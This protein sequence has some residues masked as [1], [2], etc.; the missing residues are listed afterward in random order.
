MAL[1][2]VAL[3]VAFFFAMNIGA[4]GTAA[5]MGAA[6]GSGVITKRWAMI[7]VAL[8][9]FLGASLGGKE[10]VK[11]ISGG[12][13]PASLLNIQT[14]LVI[15]S[16]AAITLFLASLLGIPLS[17]SE[18]TVGSIVGVGISYQSVY[19]GKLVVIVAF[20]IATPLLSML[21]GFVLGK[22]IQRLQKPGS[23]AKHSR[24]GNLLG[25]IL[26]ATGFFEAF[27][28]GMN[29]VANAVGPVIGAGMIT[30]TWGIIFGGAFVGLGAILLGGRVIETNG[31]KIIK[32]SLLQGSVVSATGG[33]LVILASVLGIP[34]PHTQVST[35]AILG[36]GTAE[37]GFRLLQKQVIHKILKVWLVSPVSSL[38][39]S[40]TLVHLILIPNLYVVTVIFCVFI[41]TVGFASLTQTIRRENRSINDQGSGI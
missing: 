41:A 23:W 24:M 27:S 11:T 19:T 9:A 16:S 38:V 21:I 25:K 5:S 37:K 13:I 35:S 34:V 1:Q 40:Y 12:I 10:V 39:I 6:Y 32:L 4:S 14:V 29:N 18:V 30:S 17:T 3:M 15:L 8:G 20:W 28:A 7:L 31:K 33:G 2:Y 22:F 36:V 26:I